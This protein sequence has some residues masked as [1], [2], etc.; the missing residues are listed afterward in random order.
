MI[1][2]NK[3]LFVNF[4]TNKYSIIYADP[5]WSYQD[6]ALAGNRGACCKY[7]TL[8]ID[9]ISQLPVKTIA[10]NNCF[11][12][13]WV[14]FPKLQECFKVINAWGFTYKTVAFVWV[15]TNK[16]NAKPFIGLGRYTRA[17]AEICLLATK[18]KLA[19][20]KAN[21]HSIIMT[22]IQEHSKKP[23]EVRRR[24]VQLLGD[25]PRIELFSRQKIDGWDSWGNELV[26]SNMLDSFSGVES[27]T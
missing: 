23:N 18:G 6:K 4:P 20:R 2:E 12:F 1:V 22:P 27:E 8:S 17:N 10:A 14:T 21:V 3:E 24:I 11:L 26:E 16:L 19:R 13:L 25:L 15:K 5:A 7:P 9:E